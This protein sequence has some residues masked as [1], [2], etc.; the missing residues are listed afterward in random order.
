MS[1]EMMAVI[2][3]PVPF[4]KTKFSVYIYIDFYVYIYICMY[5]CMHVYVCINDGKLPN[6]P[7]FF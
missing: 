4:V 6:P 5:V 7:C 1:T 3:D 2:H